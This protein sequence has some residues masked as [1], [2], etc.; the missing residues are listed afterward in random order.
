VERAGVALFMALWQG[1]GWI[2]KKALS[3]TINQSDRIH[4][5]S[6][7]TDFD[8]QINNIRLFLVFANIRA[9]TPP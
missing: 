7:T 9:K 3:F 8:V 1:C 2:N 5:R 4:S 6:K